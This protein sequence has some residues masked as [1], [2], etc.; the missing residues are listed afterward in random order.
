M[1]TIQVNVVDAP[2]PFPEKL[3]AK[4]YAFPQK[5]KER[6]EESDFTFVTE[7]DDL[8]E[9]KVVEPRRRPGRP[10]SNAAAETKRYSRNRPAKEPG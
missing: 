3:V 9:T 7:D 4:I 6:T 2:P 1:T 10:K 5:N 8:A